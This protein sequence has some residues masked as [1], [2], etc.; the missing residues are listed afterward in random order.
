MGPNLNLNRTLNNSNLRNSE[1]IPRQQSAEAIVS[2]I[3]SSHFSEVNQRI[4][5]NL[6]V[7]NTRMGIHVYNY[8]LNHY[9]VQKMSLEH[10][11]LHYVQGRVFLQVQVSMSPEILIR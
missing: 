2:D 4:L 11:M 5:D 10:L 8:N 1:A 9:F 6:P 3:I 7:F